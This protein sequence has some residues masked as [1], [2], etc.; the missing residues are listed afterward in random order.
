MPSI[1]LVDDDPDALASASAL[2]E[3]L[4]YQT[5][6]V[7]D[8]HAALDLLRERAAFDVLLT[9]IVMPKMSGVMLASRVR[10]M[11]NPICV[12]YVTGYAPE[13]VAEH[14][15]LHGEVLV[16]PWS[17]EELEGAIRRCVDSVR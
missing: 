6:A 3:I 8:P 12:V 11:R 17:V 15:Q 10:D 4:G 13:L 1:L 9:D 5:T 7:D 14:G 2:L 16:K